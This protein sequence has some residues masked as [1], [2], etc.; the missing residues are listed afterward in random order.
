MKRI[1]LS[2]SPLLVICG[3]A[4]GL[5]NHPN[6]LVIARIQES[7]VSFPMK[8]VLF[9]DN[10]SVNS[11]FRQ[12]VGQINLISDSI[13]FAINAGD[14]AAGGGEE[15][16]RAYINLIDSLEVPLISVI[17]NHEMNEPGGM[18]RYLEYFGNPNFYF[19]YDRF[20]FI[21]LQDTHPA[22]S[23]VSAG[24]N[25]YYMLTPAQLDLL[26]G[27]LSEDTSKT[28]FV[29]MHCPAAIIG[30][31]PRVATLGG[32]YYTP[33][34]LEESGSQRFTDL[35]RDHNVR[36]VGFGHLHCYDLYQP[37]DEEYGDAI[38]IIT[39]GAGAALNPW[40]YDAPYGGMLHH[41]L[42]L[43]LHE[44][45]GISVHLVRPAP[46]VQYDPAYEQY[47]PP[48]TEIE[49]EMITPEGISLFAFPNPFNSECKIE[50][51]GNINLQKLE[52]FNIKGEKIEEFT[53]SSGYVI[54]KAENIPSGVYIIRAKAGEIQRETKV[55]LLQ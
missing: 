44:D 43:E 52:I 32:P 40:L 10:Y 47:F 22:D 6:E 20:R 8:V 29:F 1:I 54:W 38:Y 11:T 48:R 46:D 27:L 49:E 18:E 34:G 7:P 28:T 45:G 3:A 26:E 42:V 25:V 33:S 55:L 37:N 41:F 50:C 51:K 36:L 31:Y 15:G 53:P 23:G 13:S 16:Y 14:I 19:D 39:G 17:G 5:V 2:I 12:I 21:F 35:A 24:E 4:C 30:H 9:G